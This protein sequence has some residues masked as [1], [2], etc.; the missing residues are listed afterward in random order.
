M[1][2]IVEVKSEFTREVYEH[3]VLLSFNGDDDAACF[4]EWWLA[5][6]ESLYLKFRE[7]RLKS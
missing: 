3:E 2:D 1:G 7:R 5:K 6:G 4:H